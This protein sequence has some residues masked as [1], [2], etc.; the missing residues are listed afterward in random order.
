MSKIISF[1]KCCFEKNDHTF[2]QITFSIIEDK[3]LKN[4]IR[5][6]MLLIN[7]NNSKT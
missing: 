3:A 1:N 2:L 4:I 6:K 7:E 5:E